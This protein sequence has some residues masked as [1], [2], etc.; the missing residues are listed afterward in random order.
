MRAPQR[1]ELADLV[2]PPSA[3]H[4]ATGRCDDTA[5]Q[6]AADDHVVEVAT[7]HSTFREPGG[8][9]W[10][11]HSTFRVESAVR[12][13]RR[14]RHG[15]L[16]R[17]GSDRPATRAFVKCVI[18]G[19]V[20]PARDCFEGADSALQSSTVDPRTGRTAEVADR[21]SRLSRTDTASGSGKLGLGAVKVATGVCACSSDG[22]RGVRG[23]I[24]RVLDRKSV[25]VC[26]L[27]GRAKYAADKARPD[28][29]PRWR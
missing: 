5:E 18:T 3:R 10:T 23:Y 11:M 4:A 2:A 29:T 16:D 22:S 1:L 28:A 6:H 17:N 13:S 8:N 25:H 15:G 21:L 26:D 27:V 12:Q 9:R 14:L 20:K 24:F 19:R 7:V